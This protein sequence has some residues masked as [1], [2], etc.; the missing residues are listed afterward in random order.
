MKLVLDNNILFSLMKLESANSYL[1]F[2]LN[3]G[4]IAPEFIKSEFNKY[5]EY[6]LS[7]S[8]LSKHEFKLRQTEV[9]SNI[10]FFK[11]SEYKH[12]LKKSLEVMPD[13]EDIDFLAL[14]L[15][16]NSPIWSNDT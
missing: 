8:R 7:K 3:V 6:C 14:A 15:F 10:E 4:F 9:E 16:T 1:F 11:L 5:K 2:S 12:F 13:P